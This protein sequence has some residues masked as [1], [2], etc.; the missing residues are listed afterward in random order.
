MSKI[1]LFFLSNHREGGFRAYTSNLMRMLF[2]YGDEPTCYIIGKRHRTVHL[3]DG[4]Y[5]TAIT[6]DEA[7]DLAKNEGGLIVAE[8]WDAQA[9]DIE[10]LLD[11]GCIMMMHDPRELRDELIATLQDNRTEVLVIRENNIQTLAEYGI[12]STYL[13]HIYI[14][15]N[16]EPVEKIVH[17]VSL[18]RLD[19]H[20][21]TVMLVEANTM[22]PP[23][24]QIQMHGIP[25]RL[26]CYH[27][28]RKIDEDWERNY[29]GK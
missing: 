28:L 9:E 3:A 12:S 29:H 1:N 16:P 23:D 11:A 6:H 10:A 25:N 2:H 26:Y 8:W 13:P 7:V 20:K 5:C 21:N 22:L 24:R 14:P 17:A 19:W 27:K 4:M 15:I 18:A